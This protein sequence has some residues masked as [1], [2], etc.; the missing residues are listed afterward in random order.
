[1]VAGDEV[2]EGVTKSLQPRDSV[3][4]CHLSAGIFSETAIRYGKM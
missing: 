2:G 4:V 3:C 1:M